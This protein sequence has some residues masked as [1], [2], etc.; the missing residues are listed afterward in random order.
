MLAVDVR[1]R[2][3]RTSKASNEAES[4]VAWSCR[5]LRHRQLHEEA[6][7]ALPVGGDPDP[8]VHAVHELAADVEPEPRSADAAREVRVEP[9]EL[10]EDPAVL[11]RRDAEP[12]VLDPETD[13]V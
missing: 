8:P 4:L 12:L 5:W 6:G 3:A 13:A 10:L 2:A 9:E 1:P 7:P 11:G